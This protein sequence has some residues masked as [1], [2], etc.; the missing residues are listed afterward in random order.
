MPHACPVVFFFFFLICTLLFIQIWHMPFNSIKRNIS[1]EK[2]PVFSAHSFHRV[3][4]N[5]LKLY[6][7]HG[8]ASS[9]KLK[10]WISISF[11]YFK[12]VNFEG[13]FSSHLS[14]GYNKWIEEILLVKGLSVAC[15]TWINSCQEELMPKKQIWTFR[16]YV[17]PGKSYACF[18]KENTGYVRCFPKFH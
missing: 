17:S 4:M 3:K 14:C 8:T 12:I 1:Y 10:P 5:M 9:E 16:Q 6:D 18:W 2:D 7:L 11:S 13:T 15:Q